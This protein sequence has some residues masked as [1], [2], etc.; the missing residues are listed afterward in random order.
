MRVKSNKQRKTE[1]KQ[2][3]IARAERLGRLLK[4]LDPRDTALALSPSLTGVVLA[5]ADTLA[6]NNPGWCGSFPVA[7][8]DKAFVCRDCAEPSVWTAA[9]QRWWY[10]T[11]GATMNSSAVR[12]FP[13][14]RAQ[15]AHRAALRAQPGADALSLRV[16]RLRELAAIR[17]PREAEWA[18]IETALNSKWTGV[19]VPAIQALAGWAGPRAYALLKQIITS[20][21]SSN[22]DRARADAAQRILNNRLTADDLGWAFEEALAGRWSLCA[23]RERAEIGA[24]AVAALPSVMNEP[25]VDESPPKLRALLTVLAAPQHANEARKVSPSLRAKISDHPS[26]AVQRLA[27][28]VWPTPPPTTTPC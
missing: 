4:G 12:C 25:P 21:G 7:Y 20:S 5:N 15:Q 9:Q 26:A 2:Q 13:C 1:I 8:L 23:L 17:S 19:A 18:E 3:R 28:H 6:H 10:E 22:R 27:R 14:R 16:L 24:L 11:V